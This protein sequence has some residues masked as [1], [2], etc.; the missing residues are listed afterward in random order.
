MLK[1]ACV[2]AR[3]FTGMPA[4]AGKRMWPTTALRFSAASLPE[5]ALPVV[6]KL[7]DRLVG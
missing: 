2:H 6:A 1:I 7:A 4:Q 3:H 5:I